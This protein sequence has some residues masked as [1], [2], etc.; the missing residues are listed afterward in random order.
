MPAEALAPAP[1]PAA[2]R[3]GLAGVV[4]FTAILLAASAERF[5]HGGATRSISA[6]RTTPG[7]Q[8]VLLVWNAPRAELES[9]LLNAAPPMTLAALQAQHGAPLRVLYERTYLLS[10][11]FTHVEH[12]HTE[13][14]VL[15]DDRVRAS[16]ISELVLAVLQPWAA[17]PRRLVATC[18][19]AFS[20]PGRVLGAGSAPGRRRPRDEPIHS[21]SYERGNLMLPRVMAL[22]RGLLELYNS[23][24][25]AQLRAWVDLT[26]AAG[27]A[28]GPAGGASGGR[29]GAPN[30][31][32][33]GGGGQQGAQ[34]DDVLLN[35]IYQ[36]ERGMGALWPY[37][38]ESGV[39]GVGPGGGADAD[40]DGGVDSS[41]S[42]SARQLRAR[43]AQYI[44]R[45][46]PAGA[47]GQPVPWLRP[48]TRL[49]LNWS[50][51]TLKQF[52]S[53]AAEILR[54]LRRD[55]RH[56]SL[57]QLSALRAASDAAAA[58]ADG[59]AGP[60]ARVP[61]MPFG[62][63]VTVA[64]VATEFFDERVA[65][66]GGFG[67]ST[68]MIG[69]LFKQHPEL[70]ISVVY[71]MAC[72]A[73]RLDG[74]F[75]Q[76]GE[77]LVHGWPLINLCNYAE[78][79]T[80]GPG[81]TA[82]ARAYLT[83]KARISYFL[84]IDYRTNYKAAHS[85]MPHVPVLLWARDPRTQRQRKNIEHLVVPG[86]HARAQGAQA[87]D[88]RSARELWRT[89]RIGVGMT[90]GPALSDRVPE[91][92]SLP[93]GALVR[94]LPNTIAPCTLHGT[95]LEPKPPGM[96]APSPEVLFLAR[97]DPYKRPWL[98]VELARAFP[99][100]TFFA[101]G[102]SHFSG[103]GSFRAPPDGEVPNLRFL[104][105]VTSEAAKAERLARAWFVVNLSVHEGVA[106][107]WLEAFHC[108]TPVLSTVN[109]GNLV[110]LFGRFAGEWKGTGLAGL[111]RIKAAFAELLSNRTLRA[112]LGVAARRHVMQT[113]NTPRLAR[114]FVELAEATEALRPPG[115][116]G[117]RLAVRRGSS[118]GRARRR[119]S[120]GRRLRSDGPQEAAA[121]AARA[122]GGGG[123]ER[124]RRAPPLLRGRGAGGAQLGGWS[125]GTSR[126]G[127][128]AARGALGGS[129]SPRLAPDLA[130]VTGSSAAAAAGSV[131][132]QGGHNRSSV[133]PPRAH[134]A[135]ASQARAR[136]P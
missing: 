1:A 59:L 20:P 119:G 129:S 53:G 133:A 109:P 130:T 71:V 87:P 74:R 117:A 39:G 42:H 116:G 32:T 85:I 6:V 26:A 69:T 122:H 28:G 103:A 73:E 127:T 96:E 128:A 70:G 81:S 7:C 84:F 78:G 13:A 47:D 80:S 95:R 113:H 48:A 68:R 121:A 38:P 110:A 22:D 10:N 114:K 131:S 18:A 23:P 112:E 43:C 16:V 105:H 54:A 65:R 27:S 101:A 5:L 75:Y 63:P 58:A 100:V 86:E 12:V 30:A 111:P 91:A 102:K 17:E 136:A 61:V 35:F 88:A 36:A 83:S 15:F 11:R 82:W 24:K 108:R 34:C 55:S 40:A 123:G 45:T 3:H 107:S 115:G 66:M 8:K 33:K 60:P 97:L 124:A 21:R 29:G 104:G 98:L 94:E 44:H 51:D 67:Y 46:M 79:A 126:H 50:D 62:R 31:P 134:W 2:T 125:G 14:V 120:G 89:A 9:A 19:R 25:Y 135:G 72:M 56:F 77:T 64:I 41:H 118:S 52:G 93:P 76:Q 132:A 37:A 106:I 49:W 99:H 92:Y 4:Q 57:N 90:Y